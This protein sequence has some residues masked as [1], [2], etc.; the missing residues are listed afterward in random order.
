MSL[1]GQARRAAVWVFGPQLTT[2]YLP[3][4][5]ARGRRVRYDPKRSWTERY[6][7]LLADGELEDTTT[8][9]RGANPLRTRYHYNAVEN[10]ILE[11]ALL[12]GLPDRPSVLDVGTGSGHWI[13]FYRN[14][15][16]AREVVG[17]EI[18]GPAAAALSA[19][20]A[21][22][23]EVEIVEGDVTDEDFA[24]GRLFDVVSAVD[25][26]FHVVDD[27]TWEQTVRRLASHLG[28]GGR[29]VVAEHVGLV[30]HD[31]GFR[32][33]DPQR[34]EEPGPNRTVVTKRVRS[35]RAW[36]ACARA[37]GLAVLDSARVRKSRAQ[38]TPANRLLV[39][40]TRDE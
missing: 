34:G 32:R 26:L 33:P 4:L 16:G 13:D 22:A 12:R 28:P 21:D 40:G 29:L 14:A 30:S 15:L 31:A 6:E 37:A 36:R 5:R 9:K 19:A 10:A 1:R 23:S 27:E 24:V 20:Y 25:V 8:I 18:S 17:I 39:L 7:R 3:A 35:A 2:Q 11:H 38:P